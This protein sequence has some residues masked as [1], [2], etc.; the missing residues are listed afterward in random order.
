M[1]KNPTVNDLPAALALLEARLA[2][3]EISFCRLQD[4]LQGSCRH[5]EQI[6]QRY[7]ALRHDIYVVRSAL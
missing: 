2:A 7:E 3:I 1:T 4:E 6:Q 5:I